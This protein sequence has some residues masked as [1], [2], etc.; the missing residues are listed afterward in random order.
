MNID[1]INTSARFYGSALGKIN[2]QVIGNSC[3]AINVEL[4]RKY[5][6]FDSAIFLGLGDGYLLEKIG[7]SFEKLIVLEAS[8][9]LVAQA[10][11]AFTGSRGI[12]IVQSYFET[13]EPADDNKVSCILGNHVLEHLDDP[14]QVLC[15]SLA[16]LKPGGIAI[17][18]V[19]NATSLHRR[20]GVQLGL[21][22]E[23]QALSEQDQVVGHR[24]VYDAAMLHGDVVSAGYDVLEA[25]GFNLKLVSQAQMVDWPALLHDAI[26]QVSRECPAEFCSNLYVVCQ[27]R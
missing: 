14:V 13:Y 22:G 25:G 24:R 27:R 19:P 1:P 12:Q 26:Y 18:T 10:Q 2:A 9:L 4:V 11:C 7:P 16:W 23:V 17:F 5:G 21:L 20:I 3:A 6:R 15:K 8:E